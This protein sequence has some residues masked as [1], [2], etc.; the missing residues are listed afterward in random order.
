M[1][2]LPTG[3]VTFLFT[4]IEGSTRLW[5]RYPHAMPAALDRHDSLLRESIDAGGGVVFRTVGDA[6][7]AAFDS[8][9]S[10]L[11]A[12]L[13]SQRALYAEPWGDIGALR[14]RMALHTSPTEVR[15]GS[16]FGQPLNRVARLLAAAHGGQTLISRATHE[17]VRDHLPPGVALR[18]LGEHALRDIIQPER[19]F[20]LMADDLPADFPPLKTIT[21]RPRPAAPAEEPPADAHISRQHRLPGMPGVDYEAV[22]KKERER[23]QRRARKRKTK[24]GGGLF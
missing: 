5:E 21:N 6:F 12:A 4:D 9:L 15:D 7:F 22:L 23:Q 24:G 1:S 19:I 10:A 2:A 16:Y 8:A 13:Q 11:R 14:V 3:V 20:Q 18:D 17:L